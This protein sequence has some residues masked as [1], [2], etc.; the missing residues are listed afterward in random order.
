VPFCRQTPF[1]LKALREKDYSPNPQTL[2]EHLKKR[3]RELG[4]FQREAAS[5]MGIGTDTYANWEKGKTEP[6]ATQFQPVVAFLGYDRTPAP[7]TLSE[8][9]KAKRRELSVTFA[10]VARYLEWDTGTLS[11]YLNGTWHMPPPRAALLE[12][13]LVAGEAELA[14]LWQLPRGR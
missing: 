3:R 6:V 10:Q 12:A 5:R 11:R 9:L 2:G 1:T 8:R 14:R 7:E 4:L 13:F